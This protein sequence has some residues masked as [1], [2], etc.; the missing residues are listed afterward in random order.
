MT[1]FSSLSV[2]LLCSA[3]ALCACTTTRSP[4]D[5]PDA[6]TGAVQQPFKDLNI[7]RDQ[8]PKV[9]VDAAKA[10]YVETQPLDCDAV[11][12]ELTQLNKELGPDFDAAEGKDNDLLAGALRSAMGLPFRGVVRKLTGAEKRDRQREHA[13]LAGIARRGFLKGVDRK[14]CSAPPPL[15]ASLTSKSAPKTSS[16]PMPIA[17]GQAAPPQ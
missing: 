9:L 12:A 5:K 3:L 8:T 14:S 2:S 4:A 13:I 6:L 15:Q 1:S 16:T 17:D 11:H 7:V 10:P